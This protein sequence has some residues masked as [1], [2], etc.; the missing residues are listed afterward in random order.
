MKLAKIVLDERGPSAVG[1]AAAEGIGQD[2]TTYF[3]G[4]L[5]APL[6]LLIVLTGR[7]GSFQRIDSTGSAI[8]IWNTTPEWFWVGALTILRVANVIITIGI[9]YLTYRIGTTI[10][11]RR[12][13]RLASVFTA[14][15]LAVFQSAHEVNED[16]PMVFLLLVVLLISLRYLEH[17]NNR[18]F[19]AGCALGGLTIAFK[20]TGGVVV[21]FLA[22]AYTI[23]AAEHDSPVRAFWQPKILAAG[24][25]LGLVSIYVGIPNL[26]VGGPEWLAERIFSA[27]QT[28]AVTT[29]PQGYQTLLSY[30]NGLGLPLT[31]GSVL[32]FAATTRVLLRDWYTHRAELIISVGL[33]SYLLVFFVLWSQIRTHHTLPTVPLFLILLATVL[34]R[35]LRDSGSAARLVV[36][37]LLVTTAIYAAGGLFQY[38]TEP[39]DQSAKWLDAHAPPDATVTIYTWAP[40]KAGI[41]HG[42]PIDHYDFGRASFFPGENSTERGENYT[43]W[44]ISTPNRTPEYIHVRSGI[45]GADQYPRRGEFYDRLI[46]GDH[47]GYVPAA[48]FGTRANERSYAHETVRAGLIPEIEKRG[49]YIKVFARDRS[50]LP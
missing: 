49:R 37:V 22:T 47:Y 39:R 24:L 13:G 18:E 1:R 16:T 23:R 26:L 2:A 28:K 36:A 27:H 10:A 20:L 17:G 38:T 50:L 21:L 29:D 11:D 9:I 46:A 15:S 14:L 12:A 6:F 7:L 31:V 44:V 5:L 32:G 45:R 48:E 4:I 33:L 43:D 8:A 34:S 30:L 19:L 3:H 42:R 41:D 25:G 40:G 35:R